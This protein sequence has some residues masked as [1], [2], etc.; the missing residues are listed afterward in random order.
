MAPIFVLHNTR[1]LYNLGLAKLLRL[2]LLAIE[3][4]QLVFKEELLKFILHH[5]IV[6]IDSQAISDP[7]GKV[8]VDM[9]GLISLINQK[10]RCVIVVMPDAPSN[11][12]V[13]FSD[14]RNFV[15]VIAHDPQCWQL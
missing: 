10:Y 8:L 5:I 1:R 6:L 4:P 11:N 12:L 14:S 9:F 7:L 2:L 3:L 13:N 15:P